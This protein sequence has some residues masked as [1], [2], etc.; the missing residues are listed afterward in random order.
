MKVK[1]TLGAEQD[2]VLLAI[3]EAARLLGGVSHKTVRRMLDAGELSR[4]RIRG[5]VLV[6]RAEIL[7]LVAR[8]TE[9]TPVMR[10]PGL[11]GREGVRGDVR[12]ES[13]E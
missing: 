8:N 13:T 9:A 10:T 6:S 11:T 5:R 2:A 12:G 1:R 4:V 7:D 3:E